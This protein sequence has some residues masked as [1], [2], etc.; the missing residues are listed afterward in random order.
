MRTTTIPSRLLGTMLAIAFAA[1]AH[2]P[3]RNRFSAPLRLTTPLAQAATYVAFEWG[4]PERPAAF[5]D[6]PV[7]LVEGDFKDLRELARR[8]GDPGGLRDPERFIA[9]EL[10]AKLGALGH[11]DVVDTID[12]FNAGRCDP[13]VLAGSLLRG[14]NELI[15]RGDG[16]EPRLLD[17]DFARRA[18]SDARLRSAELEYLWQCVEGRGAQR[19][20][21]PGALGRVN[22]LLLEDLFRRSL[23]RS[24]SVDFV[25]RYLGGEF[26]S[27]CP[28]E[29]DVRDL[30]DACGG[31]P[32]ILTREPLLPGD[33]L[34]VSSLTGFRKVHG[35][36]ISP[37][38]G[39]Y[40]P[41]PAGQ[42]ALA[43]RYLPEDGVLTG[44]EA[45]AL[46]A[47]IAANGRKHTIEVGNDSP[48]LNIDHDDAASLVALL[49]RRAP[50][51]WNVLLSPADGF[52][53][54]V[55][56]V[57]EFQP[58]DLR[59]R[60]LR[61]LLNAREPQEARW[62]GDREIWHNLLEDQAQTLT[63]L[64]EADGPYANLLGL[65]GR[66]NDSPKHSHGWFE[67]LRHGVDFAIEVHRGAIGWGHPATRGWSLA[68][69]E[70]SRILG[71]VEARINTITFRLSADSAGALHEEAGDEVEV[72]VAWPGD[73]R[74]PNLRL[75]RGPRGLVL[76]PVPGWPGRRERRVLGAGDLRLLRRPPGVDSAAAPVTWI[77]DLPVRFTTPQLAHRIR[78]VG[79]DEV[80]G[81]H[82]K[83]I[84]LSW[85]DTVGLSISAERQGSG[86]F[87]GYVTTREEFLQA[88][89]SLAVSVTGWERYR[90]PSPEVGGIR[91]LELRDLG[92]V[93]VTDDP[94]LANVRARVLLSGGVVLQPGWY[95]AA[96]GDASKLVFEVGA[97]DRRQASVILRRD[98]R[99]LTA[100][101]VRTVIGLAPSP[102]PGGDR[103]ATDGGLS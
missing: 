102:L 30:P 61:V 14:L 49:D 38:N 37:A 26:V 9:A 66:G 18:F 55:I 71:V 42:L 98:L 17:T 29:P 96:P 48:T 36:G 86:I 31:Q 82:G 78:I 4:A 50:R 72:T 16:T 53:H 101:S 34:L 62:I 85:D 93:D 90:L 20:R 44:G 39:I 99:F 25:T 8:L 89:G 60:L 95:T 103:D 75:R 94:K 70:A 6:G 40:G 5:V 46:G 28:Q 76:E 21:D 13:A 7:E 65:R 19:I 11:D 51:I 54:V 64:C 45:H 43:I 84:R 69:W 67:D 35:E 63:G 12:A 59:A 81:Q 80:A 58:L 23:R 41:P 33:L 88:V 32:D 83:R 24:Y 92:W 52:L 27:G 91:R 100:D 22:R 68:E 15:T 2:D 56:P 3:P 1:C 57:Q 87:N 73:T 97:W 47:W 79:T 74:M 77:A 10:R